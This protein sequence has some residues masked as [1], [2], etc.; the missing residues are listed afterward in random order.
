MVVVTCITVKSMHAISIIK[1]AC[2]WTHT[3]AFIYYPT[4]TAGHGVRVVF[5]KKEEKRKE[6]LFVSAFE[7]KL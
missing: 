5:R 6:M 7:V 3:C 1:Q 4:V 2:K